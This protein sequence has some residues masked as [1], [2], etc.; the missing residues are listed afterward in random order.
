MKKLF[1]VVLATAC[2][3]GSYAGTVESTQ[4]PAATALANPAY[5]QQNNAAIKTP[6][7]ARLKEIREKAIREAEHATRSLTGLILFTSSIMV[8][9]NPERYHNWKVFHGILAGLYGLANVGLFF[10]KTPDL[11]PQNP[12]PKPSVAAKIFLHTYNMSY[13]V[14]ALSIP[15]I[16]GVELL[17]KIVKSQYDFTSTFQGH[18]KNGKIF[19]P[20]AISAGIFTSLE[21][22][23]T[24]L[25]AYRIYKVNQ[26]HQQFYRELQAHIEKINQE[27]QQIK[28]NQA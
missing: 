12:Q 11:A 13:Y 6:D 25:L 22:F 2:I 19:L 27:N 16:M 17:S 7:A 15:A 10:N 9:R 5:L 21:L 8:W 24:S 20:G 1:S 3:T 26:M 18:V 14:G 23:R 4:D 28:E